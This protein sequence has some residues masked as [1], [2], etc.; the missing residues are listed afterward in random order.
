MKASMKNL[1]NFTEFRTKSP[2]ITVKKYVYIGK[3]VVYIYP[4]DTTQ[5][6]RP[7]TPY[8]YYSYK[9][10]ETYLLYMVNR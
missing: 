5:F 2:L 3:S 4:S 1:I 9:L 10:L 8:L 6:T 7:I